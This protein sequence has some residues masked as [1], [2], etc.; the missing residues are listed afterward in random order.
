MM[1][2][3]IIYGL[4][5]AV[6]FPCPIIPKACLGAIPDV[7]V[8]DAEVPLTLSCSVVREHNWEA[9]P[10]QFLLNAGRRAG[11][12][13]IKNGKT[14]LLQ[15]SADAEDE[16]ICTIFCTSV[17]AVLVQ[18]RGMLVLHANTVVALDSA[19]AIAGE[20]GAGKSTTQAI[21]LASGCK[22][23]ADDVTVL[24]LNSKN[25]VEVMPGLPK[26]NLCDDTAVKLGHDLC[27]LTRNPL[28]RS[29][30]FAPVPKS[31][32]IS[33]PVLLKTIYSIYIH[34]GADLIYSKLIGATKF[35][36]IQDC[37]YGPQFSEEL[38]K[39]F[40][41]TSKLNNQVSVVSI[42]RPSKGWSANEIAKY[43][44][45]EQHSSSHLM[46]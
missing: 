39:I 4:V 35:A 33:T 40:E 38:N 30:V 11:R 9:M 26:L 2:L 45:S 16:I 10:G 41:L 8:T 3:Y 13:F 27:G 15:R 7:T 14:V 22:M 43:I 6:P 46:T 20:S 32:L 29:K 23:L 36:A 37:M 34:S 5:V 17:M 18:Q 25:Q 19:L 24:K 21:L 31:D 12:F 42:G 28:R 1:N 44:I